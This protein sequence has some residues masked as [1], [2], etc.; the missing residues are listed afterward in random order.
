MGNQ[1]G[2]KL[3][4][5][6]RFLLSFAGLL[7][8]GI[9]LALGVINA[10]A[11]QA[12][13]FDNDKPDVLKTYSKLEKSEKPSG[14]VSEEQDQSSFPVNSN[15]MIQTAV[16]R[17]KKAVSFKAVP[18]TASK[19]NESS[20]VLAKME[21]PVKVASSDS[22]SNDVEL[23]T[24]GENKYISR[25]ISSLKNGQLE[26]AV[27]EFS[28]AINLDPEK[29][30]TYVARGSAYFRLGRF[31]K[32]L[33]DYNRAI[34]I[35]PDLAAA[36]QNRGSVYYRQNQLDKAISDYSRAI[37]I[38]PDF[39]V[40]YVDRG[41]IYQSK[42]RFDD[43][44]S[45]FS[46]VLKLHPRSAL[47]YYFMGNA[48]YMKKRFDNAISDYSNAIDMNP[49]FAVAYQNRGSAYFIKGDYQKAI[50]DYSKAIEYNPKNA[51]T[52]SSRGNAYFMLSQLNNAISDFNKAIELDPEMGKTKDA[53]EIE[54]RRIAPT[55][56]TLKRK[57][58]LT[59][60]QWLVKEKGFGSPNNKAYSYEDFIWAFRSNYYD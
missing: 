38:N 9:P 52:Y 40:A 23:N 56:S 50:S 31:D 55:G 3:G 13:S 57:V 4:L 42:G 21:T 18:K 25:G 41:N 28:S 27:S 59:K 53:Q 5:M 16:N 29:A 20:I 15:T 34:E 54:C 19:D 48:Y 12:R 11:S 8:L 39:A 47:I 58:C 46:K 26:D 43:A 2:Y 49:K 51:L 36:Y 22:G 30:L 35:D 17:E 14:T 44:I 37:K 1:I 33:S 10:P 45:D 60:L 24:E 6:K 7:V 32:A